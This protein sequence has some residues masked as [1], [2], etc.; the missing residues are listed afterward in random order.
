MDQ[1]LNQ[2]GDELDD[3]VSPR[4][5]PSGASPSGTSPS[6]TSPS[7]AKGD[8][9]HHPQAESVVV[10]GPKPLNHTSTCKPHALARSMKH[11]LNLSVPSLL[12]SS[13]QIMGE[14]LRM[15]PRQQALFLRG[16]STATDNLAI[17]MEH[18]CRSLIGNHIHEVSGLNAVVPQ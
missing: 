12:T 16:E 10:S 13:A 15:L 8:D 6:A 3:T 1:L 18:S 7:A 11:Y 5:S 2:S 17:S 14:P 4:T 9:S